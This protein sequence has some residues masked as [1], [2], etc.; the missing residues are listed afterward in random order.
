MSTT[1]GAT[2]TATSGGM[3]RQTSGE[4]SGQT[5]GQTSGPTFR[6][7]RRARVVAVAA[8]RAATIA[9][10]LA[11]VAGVVRQRREAA[12]VRAGALPRATAAATLPPRSVG[13][14]TSE[15]LA[16]WVPAPPQTRATQLTATLWAGPLTI[17][18]VG[19]A[20]A[21]GRIPRWDPVRRCLVARDVGGPSRRALRGVGA[22]ANTI[23]QVV[24]S[25]LPSP[26]PSLLDHEAVH[27]RQS[28]RLGPFMPVAY[29]WAGARHGY[30]DNPFERAARAGAARGAATPTTAQVADDSPAS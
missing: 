9:T 8:W 29:A 28:E 21:G 23:G 20:L 10:A 4:T 26:P 3:T 6:C 5:F 19:V 22:D 7:W 15:R 1:P 13:G 24:L 18:G 14:S 2:T 30:R 25:R 16:A 11:A 17:V 12:A 27:V